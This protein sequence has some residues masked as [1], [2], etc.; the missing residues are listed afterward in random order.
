MELQMWV[1][2]DLKGMKMN[3]VLKHKKNPFASK[4]NAK[5]PD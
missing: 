4:E 1:L 3:K 5:Y 2:E